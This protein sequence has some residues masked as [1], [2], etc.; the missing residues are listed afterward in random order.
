MS[1]EEIQQNLALKEIPNQIGDVD[2]PPGILVRA[3]PIGPNKFGPGNPNITQYELMELIPESSFLPP[4][5]IMPPTSTPMESP[6]ESTC[7]SGSV[8]PIEPIEPEIP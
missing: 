6:F 5:P 3:G 4:T 8:E 7:Q 2:P 1:E